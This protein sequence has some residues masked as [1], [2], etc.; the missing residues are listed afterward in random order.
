MDADV[1][2][3]IGIGIGIGGVLTKH[4]VGIGRVDADVDGWDACCYPSTSSSLFIGAQEVVV[5]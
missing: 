4:M 2:Y 3:S 5:F 1:V